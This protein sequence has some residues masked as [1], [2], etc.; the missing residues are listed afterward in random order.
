MIFEPVSQRSLPTL[1]LQ[2]PHRLLQ[3]TDKE[4]V[5][6]S[7]KYV[8]VNSDCLCKSTQLKHALL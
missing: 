7:T 8:K 4:A 3:L 6:A 1:Y 2:P 5:E